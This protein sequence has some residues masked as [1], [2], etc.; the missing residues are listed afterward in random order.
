MTKHELPKRMRRSVAVPSKSGRPPSLQVAALCYRQRGNSLR[1]LL[2]TSRDTGRWV[3]PKGWPMRNRTDP[4]AAA[5]EAYE[6]AGIR[7]DIAAKPIGHYTYMKWLGKGRSIPCLVRVYPLQVNE[8]LKSYP[9]TKQR[10]KKWFRPEKAAEKV[11]EPELA[12]LIRDFD[13]KSAIWPD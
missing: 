12:A 6:E 1:V 4:E 2:I 10:R 3:T 9:E 5:R 7:G 13:P 8:M 11:M